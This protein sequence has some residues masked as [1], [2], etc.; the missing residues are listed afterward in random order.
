[1]RLDQATTD[2]DVRFAPGS[3]RLF[4]ADAAVLH[5]MAATGQLA[6][7]DRVLVAAAGGPGLAAAR[8]DAISRELLEHNIITTPITLADI[9]PNS[10]V[11]VAERYLVALS[12]CPNWS[13]PPAHDFTNAVS[14]NFG[15][16]TASNLGL[17][18]AH[19]ADLASGRPP[20]LAAGRPAVSAVERY[21][22]D[23]VPPAPPAS[24]IGP[25]TIPVIPPPGLAAGGGGAGA[26]TTAGSQ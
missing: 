22:S 19:P 23:T 25:I 14:S 7:A 10:A 5:R 6:P 12:P 26:G 11:I 15:C 9:R 20:G 17:M 18:V 8:V 21:L 3:T 1:L 16:A 4:T 24:G 13:K 2:V